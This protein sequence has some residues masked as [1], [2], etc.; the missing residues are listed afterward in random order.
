MT[1]SRSEVV[2]GKKWWEGEFTEENEIIFE[3]N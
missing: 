2:W 3:D 1:E